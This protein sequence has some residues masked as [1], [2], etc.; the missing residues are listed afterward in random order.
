MSGL[1]L[2]KSSVSFCMRIMSPLFTVAIVSVVSAWAAANES[3]V[4][5]QAPSRLFKR[6]FMVFPPPWQMREQLLVAR[7]NTQTNGQG[8]STQNRRCVAA[9]AVQHLYKHLIMLN[10]R[11]SYAQR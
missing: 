3:V 5:A 2:V 9:F 7:A 4:R 10:L 6:T 11:R 1:A 8:E